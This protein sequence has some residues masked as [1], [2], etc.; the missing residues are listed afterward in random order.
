MRNI[1]YT[2]YILLLTINVFSQ[3]PNGPGGVGSM[4]ELKIWLDAN[5]ITANDGDFLSSW[6]DVSGNANN[7][8]QA[9]APL[10]PFYTLNSTINNG[11]AVSFAND[12][13]SSSSISDLDS[14]ELTWVIVSNTSNTATQVLLRSDYSAG[15]NVGSNR[16][17]GNFT[18]SSEFIS[19]SR[20][21]NGTIVKLID[22]YN[23]GSTIWHSRWDGTT[24]F[25]TYIDETLISSSS[26]ADASPSGH[27]NVFL[28][29]A[30]ATN[31]YPFTGD[32]AEL[33]IYNIC[34]NNAQRIIL[35]NYL[36]AKYS[37]GLSSND[38][39]SFD[40]TFGNELAGIG[41]E[42]ASNEHLDAQG[43]GIVRITAT[44]LDNNDYL[45]FG[46]D[47]LALNSTTTGTP[48][49]YT[50]STP[51]GE[52]FER[53]WRVT[54]AN[55]V[56][57]LTISFDVS[58]NGFGL[59]PDYEL[60]IDNDGDFSSGASVITG[61][62]SSGIVTFTVLGSELEDAYYFT[63][64]NPSTNIISIVDS[65]TWNEF[66]TWNCSCIPNSGST[67]TIDALHTVTVSAN[68]N[69]L[70]L[71]VTSTGGLDLSGSTLNI[72]G[73]LDF[74]TGSLNSLNG[75]LDVEGNLINSG[76]TTSSGSFIFV[77][78]NWDNS[79][80]SYTYFAG[81]SLTFDGSS[82]STISGS[83]NWNILTINN[84]SGVSVSSGSQDVYGVLNIVSGTF[85]TG[86]AVTLKSN[87]SGT[88]QMDDLE[89]GDISGDLTIE[90]FISMSTQGLREI[91]SPVENTNI[92]DWQNNG[93]I[94]S[95]FTN[96]TYPT[97]SYIN[98]FTYVETNALGVKN[99]GWFNAQ[100][101]N[102]DNTGP[103][104]GHRVY[105]DAVDYTLSVTGAPYKNTQVIPVTQTGGAGSADDQNGWNL[106][107]NPYPCTI[108]WDLVTKSGIED[109]VWIWNATLG[110][111]G[112][113]WS[114]G[115]SNGVTDEIAHSQAFW[116]KGISS[117]GSVTINEDD[118]VRTDKAFVKT[119]NPS[120]D[121]HI[122]L[123]GNI[124]SYKDELIVRRLPN[125]S[126]L[127][128][129]GL[130][131]PKLFTE[132]PDESPSLSVLCDD[133]IDLCVAAVN[134]VLTAELKLSAISGL[135]TQGNYTL[136]FSI[137]DGFME[138]GCIELEDLHNGIITDLRSDSSYTFV[139]S[140]T[141]MAP[142]FLL[143]MFRDY[144]VY[145]TS[146]SCYNNDDAS[147]LIE[148]DFL[149]SN[150]YDLYSNGTLVSSL[151]AN[152]NSVLF[153]DLYAGNY[154]IS[155]NQLFNCNNNI[156][157]IELNQPYEVSADFTF[158]EDTLILGQF[159]AQLQLTNTSVGFTSHEWDFDDG[160]L[161]NE[162][163]P[164]HFYNNAGTY[165]VTL[166]V[167]NSELPLC[168]DSKSYDILI[169]DSASTDI[170]NQDNYLED[171]LSVYKFENEIVINTLIDM[172][173]STVQLFNSLGQL[174]YNEN[175]ELTNS[176]IVKIEIDKT[177]QC[178]FVVISNKFGVKTF[179]LL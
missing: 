11:P 51:A 28:G 5:K 129:Q 103:L 7:F 25:D 162:V 27:N 66:S 134:D 61:T 34:L 109:A 85:T 16:I 132:L 160:N 171:Y 52:I 164:I 137:P 150:T 108:D 179:K 82:L 166:N 50:S 115:S 62:Y 157:D 102:T 173:N 154:L 6:A 117:T 124:N 170:N 3:I 149:N 93:I 141:T 158:N 44:S 121:M 67:V 74:Q 79:L 159:L 120:N 110:Q 106:I 172:N 18:N 138:Y 60:L 177:I 8:S 167:Q 78:G 71:N 15:A 135:N 118:K 123:T 174:L 10:Q 101:A 40:A 57:D 92:I 64:G 55:E 83:T 151:I 155:S 100:D 33:V 95:G 59:T 48:S 122:F 42:D 140:D 31:Q 116:V 87:T 30:T 146:A 105:M 49:A 9:S 53:T 47:G 107:G 139:S 96:S 113:H 131:F 70:D 148:G 153:D 104:S 94:F 12:F 45:L 35:D 81:D 22:S 99:N 1:F 43:E 24:L 26:I 127:Y 161:S 98:A 126:D 19:H 32:I 91:T 163:H 147:I 69:A 73:N 133:S 136:N 77:G 2:I 84:N 76:T 144:S 20:E 23:I 178:Y 65:Q 119:Y 21:S 54:E 38:K 13:L 90:R 17:W 97:F 41:R 114:G 86:G 165:N 88:A 58:S 29:A 111:Y 128:D 156:F 112:L 169:V 80:G 75:V 142:R 89:S 72:S 130:E 14:D 36:S 4:N 145:S 37:I 176:K 56:G 175:L 125:A 39:Y 68:S 63:L 168:D 143:K 152:S 46:H